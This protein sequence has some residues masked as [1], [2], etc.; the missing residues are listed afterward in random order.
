MISADG[1]GFSRTD[2]RRVA[3]LSGLATAVFALLVLRLFH[4]QIVRGPD[5][6]RQAEQNRTQI[7]PLLAPRGLIVD[8]NGDVLVDNAPRFSLFYDYNANAPVAMDQL[9]EDLTRWLPEQR[10]LIHRKMAEARRSGKMTRLLADVP[11]GAALALM[12][13]RMLLPGVNVVVEPQRR[14][15]YGELASHLLG[16]VDEVD[17]GELERLRDRGFRLGQL[18]GKSGVEK[19]YD[20][21]LR[22]EDG[23]LQFETDAA[24]RHVQIIR[25][26]PSDPGDDVRLTLDR[27][28]QA[29]AED[30]LS[31]S[32]TGR[33]AAVALD[34]RNG[35]VRVLASRPGFDFSK[36]LGAYL[37]DPSLPLFNRALQGTYPPGSVFKIVTA[38]AAL[39]Q[40]QWDTKTS[41][42]C[43]G[44]YRLG[45]QEF[46][47]WS[48]HKRQDFFGAVAWSCNFYFYNLG[49]R[50]GPDPLESLARAF[51]FGE[52]SG[53]DMPTESSGL[54]PGRAWK[55]RVMRDGWFDG[56][57]L[58]FCIGQGFVTATP[59]QAAVLIAAVANGGT[60]WRPFVVDRVSDVQ[61]QPVY[62]TEPLARGRVPLTD[63]VWAVL[64]RA[65]EGVVTIGSGR[66]V[67]RPDLL[68]GAK[69]GTAQN[70]HGEDH[71][72]FTAY[73]G[74]PG[75]PASLALA[76]FVEN[77]G[78]GSVA[79]GPV[80]REII[81][82]AFPREPK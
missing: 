69:T 23:G 65:M 26:I 51:G 24:G 80:A 17:A 7:V 75:E 11:R 53:I 73:A 27:R 71:S 34:P 44:A 42:V 10:A 36:G 76:V 22:G 8:R 20:D 52:K 16:Y 63:E 64:H 19:F 81:N 67:Q 58:N 6:V 59:L 4:L 79:A 70:P 31:R 47:C 82:A 41:Y 56:D 33:G 28:L 55:K 50:L 15:R 37:G 43:T 62:Q 60:V 2:D 5:M 1:S 46:A 13:R 39:T 9:A 74:K 30:A 78:R 25:R 29:V 61:G 32:T 57:S 66:G 14:P 68:I 48:V 21:L 72:W 12:E 40:L 49:L 77:G 3:V 45:K 35:A 18:I 54:I 38:A